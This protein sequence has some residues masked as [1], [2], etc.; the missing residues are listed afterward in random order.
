MLKRDR[1]PQT[2]DLNAVRGLLEPG[3]IGAEMEYHVQI[4]STNN[5]AKQLAAQGAPHGMLVLADS[6]I[7]G[8]GRFER[9]FHS[10]AASGIYLSV[11]LRPELDAECA[12]LL[13]PMAAV[14]AARAIERA[15][16]VAAKIKW[17]N[18][19]YIDGR[20]ACGILCEAGLSFAQGRMDY[21]V[22]GIGINVAPMT[23]PPEL[24]GIATSVSNACGR[25]V[26]RERVL[27]ALVNELNRLYSQLDDASFMAE[28]RARSNVIGREVNVLRGGECFAARALGIDDEGSLLIETSDGR[29]ETLRSGEI[30]IRFAE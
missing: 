10:P 27:A 11:I 19:V 22:A 17:V 20:K 24:E 13:T 6:Q 5:R 1:T 30:S 28:Y 29:R 23:F 3:E 21:V 4:D 26:S 12:V 15:S 9:R 14:A 25:P 16:G 7:A 2:L 8:R 18:D